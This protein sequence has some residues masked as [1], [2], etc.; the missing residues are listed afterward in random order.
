MITGPRTTSC[1]RSTT[2]LPTFQHDAMQLER[3]HIDLDSAMARSTAGLPLLARPA[4]P[5][6]RYDRR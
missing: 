3:D 1:T 4:T 2:R 5:T 6:I